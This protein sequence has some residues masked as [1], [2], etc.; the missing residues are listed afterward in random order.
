MELKSAVGIGFRYN[1]LEFGV[2]SFQVSL[3]ICIFKSETDAGNIYPTR[4]FKFSSICI[5]VFKCLFRPECA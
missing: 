5:T 4:P 2:G 1:K 3:F